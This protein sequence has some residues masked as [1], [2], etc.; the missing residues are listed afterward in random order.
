MSGSVNISARIDVLEAID[1]EWH[2]TNTMAI[3]EEY[4]E[5]R[6]G[7]STKE[8]KVYSLKSEHAPSKVNE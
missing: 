8:Q 3:E 7:N 2:Y 6:K 5:I 1:Q 4:A